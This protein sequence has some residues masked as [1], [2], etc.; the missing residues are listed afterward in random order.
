MVAEG[1]I[2]VVVDTKKQMEV[3][4]GR[5]FRCCMSRGEAKEFEIL[6]QDRRPEA[7]RPRV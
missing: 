6:R 7:R 3:V 4:S 1:A 2:R 5:V